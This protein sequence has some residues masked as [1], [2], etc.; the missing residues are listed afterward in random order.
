[1]VN[2]AHLHLNTGWM[3]IL[4]ALADDG[5]PNINYLHFPS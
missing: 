4:G 3:D 2:C 5:T 1:M